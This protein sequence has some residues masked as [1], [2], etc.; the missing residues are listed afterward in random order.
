MGRMTVSAVRTPV[1]SDGEAGLL[2]AALLACEPQPFDPLETAIVKF[3]VE[4]GVDNER[5][6]AGALVRDY[7]F[8]PQDKYM[9]HVW[10]AGNG[11]HIVAKG[12]LE[13]ILD[14]TRADRVIREWADAENRRL[15]TAGMRVLAV[16][17]G[18]LPSLGLDR[19]ADER[20]LRFIG[21]IG[22]ADPLRPG[23][24]EAVRECHEAGIRVVMIT[25]DHPLT[26]SSIAAAMGLGPDVAVATG[27]ELDAADDDALSRIVARTDIFARI[28]PEQ[29][30]RLVRV[31]RAAGQVVAMTGDGINDAPA[32]R[33][34]DIGV[35]MGERG[36]EVAREAATLVL[37]DDNFA[38]IVN[39]VRNGRRIFR[40]LQRAFAYLIAFHVP[41]LLA[42][43]A[44]PL[45]GLPLLLLPIHLILLELF[46]HPA[47]SL[48]F[49]AEPA[50]PALMQEPPRRLRAGLVP[51]PVAIRTMTAG[52]VLF[53]G[54][55]VLYW[56]RLSAGDG[57]AAARTIAF[58]ALLFGQLLLLLIERS[59]PHLV[60]AI[61]RWIDRTTALLMI[62]VLSVIAVM[63][64]IPPL[65]AILR[66][67]PLSLGG[68][69]LAVGTAVLCTSW[70]EML[71]FR[72]HSVQLLGG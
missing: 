34:A 31:L 39:A 67:E 70:Q 13:G 62:T 41:L 56:W 17:A 58:I 55:L 66:M 4:N 37:L 9:S 1:G 23:V 54:V 22:F 38:T 30:Y 25:G 12:A 21:L 14:H 27:A 51:L 36:T 16:A 19:A 65:A 15:A 24:V 52:F 72:S 18:S 10:R 3:A 43:A 32:L 64:Y 57:E 68:W 49:Q 2:E 50:P 28:R 5:L 46:L 33:E 42:A 59:A 47:I 40:N 63:T 11:N 61:P 48:V 44:I 20:A 8:D 26:A 60:V 6:Q 29:K 53:I 71:K 7:P 35:A 45:L 69:G